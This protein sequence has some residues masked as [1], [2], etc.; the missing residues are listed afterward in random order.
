MERQVTDTVSGDGERR[1]IPGDR[2]EKKRILAIGVY[3]AT[4]LLFTLAV[5]KPWL[6][7]Q[8]SPE[9]TGGQDLDTRNAATRDWPLVGGDL[10]GRHYSAV[11]QI[12][13][14]NVQSLGGAWVSKTFEDGATSRST[15]VITDGRVFLTAGSRIYA[16]DAVSGEVLW[17]YQSDTIHQVPGNVLALAISGFTLPSTQGVSTG[18]GL[19]FAGLVNGTVIALRQSD[20]SLVWGRQVGDDPPAKREGH[21]TTDPPVYWKGF[22]YIGISADYGSRGRI[23]ALDAQTGREIWHFYTVPSPGDPGHETWPQDS[24]VWKRGGGGVWLP[25][26]LDPDLGLLYFGTGNAVPQFGGEPRP[27][28]NL[29]TVSVVALDMKTGKL[30]WHYQL[31]HHDIWEGDIATPLILYDA[32]INGE[33]RKGLGAM[34]AD[35]HLF[36][37][38]RATGKPL[39]PVEERAVP[40]DSIQKTSP[41]QPYPVGNYGL[42]P[43]CA[44]WKDKIPAGFVL[45]CTFAPSAVSVPNLLAPG[46]SVRITPMTYSPDTGYFYA[47]GT[48]SIAWRRRTEDPYYFGP[49]G[50]VPGLKS[51]MVFGALDTK[52]GQLVWKRETPSE[53]AGRGAGAMS[54]AGGLLFRMIEGGNFAAFNAANGNIV[55]QS[56]TGYTGDP[57]PPASYEINGEQYVVVS[58]GPVA[59]AYKLNGKVPQASP[60][61]MPLVRNDGFTGPVDDADQIE[62]V[63]FQHDI[64]SNGNR[65]FIDEYSFNPYRAR[66]SMTKVGARVTWV[67]NGRMVHTI[68]ALDNSWTTGP[69]NPAATASVVFDRPGSYTYIC[70][71]HPW[72]YGQIIV[73]PELSG[74]DLS[75]SMEAPSEKPSDAGGSF[76]QQVLR[77]KSEYDKS[78]GSCHG[79][80]LSGRDPAPALAGDTFEL[81]WVGRSVN[82]LF[83]K[84]YS[85]MPQTNPGSLPRQTYLDILAFLLRANNISVGKDQ[86]ND[87]AAN[88]KVLK[89]SKELHQ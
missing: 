87:G 18:G 36:L 54:T 74:A 76:A 88:F 48:S 44:S 28:D 25:G 1:E 17:K 83:G 53:V 57:S 12:N 79:Q 52:T 72:S 70:K 31:I 56:Q 81:H 15:P 5:V 34:R 7:A 30:R 84:T 49:N 51:T 58:A 21:Q 61:R 23:N 24:D 2:L 10:G 67:N 68:A 62:T 39:V 27:G 86:L 66:V 63:S 75:G 11:K 38:D 50:K 19:V 16:L 78:C 29:F 37:L 43:E 32:E 40:Q 6:I 14:Q 8:Q 20:G 80:D 41:T 77:G 47:Q 35:G 82:D 65:Y 69:L 13:L 64:D 59:W 4:L 33:H 46:F 3:P 55:W 26:T 45:G 42:L 22:L 71:D 60:P 73:M 85:T 9:K 89:I